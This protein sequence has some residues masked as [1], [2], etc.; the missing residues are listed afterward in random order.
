M[1]R[2]RG[3]SLQAS[4]PNVREWAGSGITDAQALTA[5]ETAKQ[6]RSS[7]GDISPI[8]SGYLNAIL[9]NQINPQAKARASPNGGLSAKDAERKRVADQMFRRGEY[10][11]PSREI[12]ITGA[13]VVVD[14]S[15][16]RAI[17]GDVRPK[18]D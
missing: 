6:Q 16:V 7:K 3:A 9:Q 1:L 8:N 2:Q 15:T 11:E 13:A 14:G 10:A 5:L 18:L 4:D 17:R 12:D